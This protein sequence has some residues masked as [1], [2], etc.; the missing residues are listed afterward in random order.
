MEQNANAEKFQ[1]A[2]F[3]LTAPTSRFPYE[4]SGARHLIG[5]Y[6]KTRVLET[7]KIEEIV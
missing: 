4:H 1:P 5:G 6:S 7:F 2:L 3:R